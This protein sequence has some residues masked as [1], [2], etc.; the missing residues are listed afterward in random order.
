ML[1]L[2][3]WSGGR[4]KIACRRHSAVDHAEKHPRREDFL[5]C[6]I[7]FLIRLS[8]KALTSNSSPDEG[9]VSIGCHAHCIMWLHLFESAKLLF[10]QFLADHPKLLR[11]GFPSWEVN[12]W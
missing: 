1:Y 3:R 11:T 2:Y 7:S 12:F 9:I 10:D 6:R 5:L 8:V 4:V